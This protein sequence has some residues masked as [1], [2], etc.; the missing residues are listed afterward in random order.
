MITIYIFL[1][2]G[3][4]MGINRICRGRSDIMATTNITMRIDEVHQMKQNPSI[5]KSYTDVDEMRKE[6]LA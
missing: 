2:A 6:L 4:I 5:G 1:H 3:I